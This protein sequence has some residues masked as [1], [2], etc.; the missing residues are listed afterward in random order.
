MTE[1]QPL[2]EESSAVQVHLTIMQDVIRRMAENSRS[3]KVW[4]ITLVSAILV[5]V[6][7]TES[8]HALTDLAPLIAIV[9]A[10]LFLVLDTYYLALERAFRD[11]YNAF[12]C[13]LHIGKMALPDLYVVVPTGSIPKQFFAILVNPRRFSIWSFYPT[14]VVMILLV[15][16]LLM[17]SRLVALDDVRLPLGG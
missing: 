11:S 7:R 10:V 8:Q 13:K 3:C 6:A 12:V 15:W 16:W 4:C 9:P 5:L 1:Q 14:L 17:T 2:N